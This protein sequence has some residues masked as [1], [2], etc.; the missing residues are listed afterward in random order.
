MKRIAGKNLILIGFMGTGK[1]EVGRL[2]AEFLNRKLVDSDQYLTEQEGM[3][4]R[5]IFELY[6]EDYFR[7]K[8]KEA[9]Q[10]IAAQKGLV[11][12]TGGGAVLDCDNVAVMRAGGYVVWLDADT[13]AL[14]QRLAGDDTRPLLA[15]GRNLAD[16]Y[17]SRL[18][19]YS[20]AAHARVDTTG[21][22]PLAVAR[23]IMALLR[24][25]DY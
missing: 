6:G 7:R 8:E 12:S 10:L 18:P 21:K 25:A 15:G 3:P 13:A 9:I 17:R 20:R 23:E 14:A 16:I 24:D 2:M 5:D 22:T 19:Y 11:L 1:T 4:V